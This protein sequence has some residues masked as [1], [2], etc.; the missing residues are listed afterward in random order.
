MTAE[1]GVVF[2]MEDAVQ[3]EKEEGRQTEEAVRS[4]D[5]AMTAGEKQI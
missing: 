1:F 2:G 4:K 3:T 5:G